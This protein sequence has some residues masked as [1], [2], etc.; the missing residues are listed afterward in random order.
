[1]IEIKSDEY[2]EGWGAATIAAS[3]TTATTTVCQSVRPG[4]VGPHLA[5]PL[6]IGP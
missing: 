2:L 5:N 1:M 6:Q 4:S 3:Y